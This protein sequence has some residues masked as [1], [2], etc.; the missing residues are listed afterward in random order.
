[1]KKVI[2]LAIGVLIGINLLGWLRAWAEWRRNRPFRRERR[3]RGERARMRAVL[4]ASN[5][6]TRA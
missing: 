6:K 2:Y 4:L 3:Y 5:L 1:M